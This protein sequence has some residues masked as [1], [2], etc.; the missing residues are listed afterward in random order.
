[1]GPLIE[2]LKS[3]TLFVKHLT[4]KQLASIQSASRLCRGLSR[5]ERRPAG[6]YLTSHTLLVLH[7]KRA[8]V[9]FGRLEVVGGPLHPGARQSARWSLTFFRPQARTPLRE[10]AKATRPGG[11]P[12]DSGHGRA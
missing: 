10:S 9:Q 5:L 7:A 1:M 11:K 2:N 4:R 6:R 8:L 12:L 3:I